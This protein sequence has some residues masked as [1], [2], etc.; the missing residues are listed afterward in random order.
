MT[1]HQEHLET[2]CKLKLLNLVADTQCK[3]ST[4]G[5][6]QRKAHKNHSRQSL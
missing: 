2:I 6:Q 4:A 1:L 3:H 5:R